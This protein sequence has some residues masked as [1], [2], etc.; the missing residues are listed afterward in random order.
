MRVWSAG[1]TGAAAGIVDMAARYSAAGPR[2]NAT[3]FFSPDR[4]IQLGGRDVCL[5]MTALALTPFAS[6]A[7]TPRPRLVAPQRRGLNAAMVPGPTEE[8]PRDAPPP[9]APGPPLPPGR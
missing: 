5:D 3:G 7:A 6:P 4:V 2:R 1:G 8:A 9:V